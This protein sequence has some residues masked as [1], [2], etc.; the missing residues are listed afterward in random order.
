VILEAREDH[1]LVAPVGFR[2]DA[3]LS[4]FPARKHDQILVLRA[5]RHGVTT[6]R[7]VLRLRP[8][9]R[10]EG[11]RVVVEA[12]EIDRCAVPG[13]VAGVGGRVDSL[14]AQPGQLH[15]EG[16]D[17][18]RGVDV[19]VSEEDLLGRELAGRVRPIGKLRT[20]TSQPRGLVFQNRRRSC[21]TLDL[22]R[23]PVAP[24]TG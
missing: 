3:R 11:L 12:E 8:V 5:P 23:R 1:V 19:E 14:Q 4:P 24:A 18:V 7:D 16:V 2:G 22:A 10:C 6:P 17:R 21:R 13:E 9:L 15:Q 20:G